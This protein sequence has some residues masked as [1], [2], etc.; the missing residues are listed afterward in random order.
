MIRLGITGGIGSGKSY[1]AQLLHVQFGVPVYDCD[2]Q[3]KRLNEESPI[4]RNALLQL[5]GPELYDQGGRLQ[6]AK[7]ASYIFASSEH[8]SRVNAIVHPQVRMDFEAWCEQSAQPIVAV[9]SAILQESGFCSLVDYVIRVDAPVEVRIAR[10]MSRDGSTR[11]QVEA[12]L[13]HQ[14]DI[15]SPHFVVVNDGRPLL[16]QLTLIMES[17]EAMSQKRTL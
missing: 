11:Q 2:S 1:V 10:A 13:Q 5:V 3:A 4:I 6:R 17:I 7:L 12:R 9:E 14:H 15:S 16:P 8:L